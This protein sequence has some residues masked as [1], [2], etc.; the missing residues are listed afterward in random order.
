MYYRAMYHPYQTKDMKDAMKVFK[1]W[2]TKFS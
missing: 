2:L 1:K